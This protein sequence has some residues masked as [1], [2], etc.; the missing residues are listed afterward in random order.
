MDDVKQKEFVKYL[1]DRAET[2][3]FEAN[4]LL[5]RAESVLEPKERTWLE[6]YE[7]DE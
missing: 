2:H 4:K 6:D 7:D 1:L 5:D 3:I